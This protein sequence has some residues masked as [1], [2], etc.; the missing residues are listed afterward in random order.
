MRFILSALFLFLVGPSSVHAVCD[1]G[2]GDGQ[3]LLT[4][5]GIDGNFNDWAPVLADEDN[6]VCDGP[7][8][9]SYGNTLA[10]LD[11]PVPAKGRD[12]TEF[13]FTWDGTNLYLYTVRTGSSKNTQ[14]FIYYADID[15]DGL[16][17]TGEPVIGAN[18]QG[19][20]RQVTVS[21][22]TYQAVVP[23]GDPMVDQNGFGDG[24]TLPGTVPNMTQ[25]DQG[26]WGSADGLMMEIYVPW[27]IGY[28]NVA[29]GTGHSIHVSSTNVT[30]TAPSLP[31]QVEDNIGG[32][33]GGS[34]SIQYANLDF[35]GASSLQG[36]PLSTVYGP[37]HLINLGNGDDT[38]AFASSITGTHAPTVAYFLDVNSNGAYN[39]GVD[40]PIAAP[41]FL[42]PGDSMDM[43][44]AYTI[45]PGA[46]DLAT[47]VTTATSG[48]DPAVADSVTD[49]VNAVSPDIIV[50]K[51]MSVISDP[52]NGGSNPKAIP[53]AEVLYTVQVSNQGNTAA[54]T[55]SIF[56]TD[57]V[58]ADTTLFVGDLGG[59]GPVIFIDGSPA[60]GLSYTYISLGDGDDDLTFSSNNGASYAYTPSPDVDGY[61]SAVTNIRVNP[62]GPFNG[63]TGSGS[64]DF[65]IRFKVRVR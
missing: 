19:S 3:P 28:L 31:G 46:S 8:I 48:F 24:Y 53:Q 52:V 57:S 25:Y 42:A 61:D 13:A 54:D 59:A 10:D 21:L 15:N 6:I 33:G 36:G 11:V 29:A 14:N 23:S 55:D 4:T 43:L 7:N 63:D 49:T 35:S 64:P 2:N 22:G 44:V 1:C 47:I 30:I 26:I 34:G 9:D 37:H 38:F 17:E 27:G 51:S 40:T 41:V 45:A 5:I 32:C 65:Q 56:V 50:L 39:P 58:P 18:W 60:S 20:N 16:M 12:M 62:K